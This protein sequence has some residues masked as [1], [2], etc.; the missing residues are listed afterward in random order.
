MLLCPWDFPGKNTGVGC[1]AL[2]QGIFLTQGLNLYL[3]HLLGWQADVPPGKPVIKYSSYFLWYLYCLLDMF[4]VS[5]NEFF[6]FGESTKIGE[7]TAVRRTHL[8]GRPLL[9]RWGAL[10]SWFCFLTA[11]ETGGPWSRCGQVWFLLR[12][13][14]LPCW[15][16]SAH[17]VLILLS[18]MCLL[19]LTETPVLLAWGSVLMTASLITSVNALSPDTMIHWLGAS[20]YE[21]W[22][23]G[24]L[25]SI[26]PGEVKWW[27]WNSRYREW[28]GTGPRSQKF[29]RS[30]LA[31]VPEALSST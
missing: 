4:L 21:W 6:S 25:Q 24:I 2:L 26:T 8:L 20:T 11:W 31:N 16:L 27:A 1:H 19:L 15:L 7:E 18:S 29:T 28:E 14:S 22:R 10:N 30:L 5:N 13:F 23:G 9:N 3:L 12:P 17:F